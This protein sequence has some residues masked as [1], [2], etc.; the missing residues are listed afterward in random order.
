MPSSDSFYQIF[1]GFMDGILV[2]KPDL[3]VIYCNDSAVSILKA[4]SARSLL[5]KKCKQ[6]FTLFFGVGFSKLH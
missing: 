2:M 4:P 3:S 1:D 6:G 5:K